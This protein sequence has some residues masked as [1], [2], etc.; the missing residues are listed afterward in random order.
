MPPTRYPPPSP[1]MIPARWVGDGSNMPV[2]RIVMHSTVSPCER[3][4]ARAVARYFA[5]TTRPSSAHY[6]VD[7]G[8]VVQCVGDSRV[9]YHAPPNAG[10]IGVELCDYPS[11][12]S[13]ARWEG[14][15]HKAMLRRAA[16][17]VAQLCLAYDVPPYYVGWVGAR[18]GRHGIT[19]HWNIS[20]AF[21]Q[22]DHWDPGKWPRRRFMRMV[23]KHVRELRKGTP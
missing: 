7:P 2:R 10:S 12:Q 21:R 17:L 23:R 22:T 18:A 19:T 11:K 16:R 14:E 6:V 4:G 15:N 8:E 1:P 20:R 9:A 5:T 13:A 3:G